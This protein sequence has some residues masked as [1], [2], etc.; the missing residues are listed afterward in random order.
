MQELREFQN[1]TI[2]AK[3]DLKEAYYTT[4]EESIKG[5][6]KE[7]VVAAIGLERTIDELI[8]L[9]RKKK[10]AKRVL[11]DRK[12]KLSLRKWSVG[13]PKR[14]KDFKQKKN[15]VG[16]EH[17]HRFQEILLRYMEEIGVE[18]SSWMLDIETLTG[19][20]RPPK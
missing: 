7:L 1:K 8:A 11:E 2:I 6:I 3:R 17:L 5:D 19:L 4:R 10:A 13:L 9:R 15:K 18:L 16:Y 12:A 14:V 20:P